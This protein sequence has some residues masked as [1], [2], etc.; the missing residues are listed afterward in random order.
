VLA[1]SKGVGVGGG[2]DGICSRRVLASYTHLHA[3]G[4]PGWADGLVRASEGGA[5]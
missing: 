2:R 4:M 1:L 3:L 5:A